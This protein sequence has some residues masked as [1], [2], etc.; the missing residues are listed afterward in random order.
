MCKVFSFKS[1]DTASGWLEDKVP[2][3]LKSSFK[4]L[5]V[6]W[7]IISLSPSLYL[8]PALPHPL[9]SIVNA[10]LVLLSILC[11]RQCSSVM[12]S[13]CSSRPPKYPYLHTFPVGCNKGV[14]IDPLTRKNY[15]ASTKGRIHDSY[16]SLE[17]IDVKNPFK[18]KKYMNNLVKALLY[19]RW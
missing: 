4:N 9:L 5:R 3:L 10:F 11:T 2:F 17:F 19:I 14:P 7:S 8:S 16:P 13:P 1:S 18:I 6:W 15:F 12:R